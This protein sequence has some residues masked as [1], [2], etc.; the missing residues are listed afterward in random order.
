[1]SLTFSLED[2]F[3]RLLFRFRSIETPPSSQRFARKNCF[4]YVIQRQTTCSP[5]NNPPSKRNCKLLCHSNNW[6]IKRDPTT[7]EQGCETDTK[8]TGLLSWKHL[9][10]I[11]QNLVSQM[12]KNRWGSGNCCN[13]QYFESGRSNISIYSK[14]YSK[15][16]CWV[17]AQSWFGIHSS[18]HLRCVKCLG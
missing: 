8:W 5:N 2:C 15:L 17:L 12:G 4:C 3:I 7:I 10:D 16:K 1:M 9:I 14:Q 6:A 11:H 18:H 13:F